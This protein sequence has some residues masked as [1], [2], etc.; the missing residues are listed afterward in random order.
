MLPIVPMKE[1]QFW[2]PFSYFINPCP[3][4]NEPDCR[5]VTVSWKVRLHIIFISEP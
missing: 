2:P 4:V 3:A 1:P 5:R